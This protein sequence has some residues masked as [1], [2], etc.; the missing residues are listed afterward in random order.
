MHHYIK[1]ATS[2]IVKGI[3]LIL[4][5]NLFDNK[6]FKVCFSDILGPKII[7]VW[8]QILNKEGLGVGSS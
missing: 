5:I 7:K 8:Y 1:D 6:L 4:S 2:I 3:C